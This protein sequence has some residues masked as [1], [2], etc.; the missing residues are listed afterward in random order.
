MIDSQLIATLS[1][2]KG[3]VERKKLTACLRLFISGSYIIFYYIYV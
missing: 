2:V 1:A 3:K